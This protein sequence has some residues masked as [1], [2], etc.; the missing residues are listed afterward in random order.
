MF[1]SKERGRSAAG[2]FF[3]LNVTLGGISG[4]DAWKRMLRRWVCPWSGSQDHPEIAGELLMGG[5]GLLGG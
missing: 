3:L 4:L 5:V 2:R 1:H